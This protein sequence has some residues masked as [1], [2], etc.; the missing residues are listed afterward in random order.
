MII[1]IKILKHKILHLFFIC[2]L[3]VIASSGM[4]TVT[5]LQEHKSQLSLVDQNSIQQKIVLKPFKLENIENSI[6]F[7][8][9]W[10]MSKIFLFDQ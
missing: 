7:N 5:A 10:V 1:S 2:L 4:L 8:T 3:W 6:E 9:I